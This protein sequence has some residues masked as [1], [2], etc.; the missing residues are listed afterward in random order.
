MVSRRS[1]AWIQLAARREQAARLEADRVDPL[2]HTVHR[3]L[4]DRQS[5][6]T[7]ELADLLHRIT[8]L[9]VD[10]RRPKLPRLIEPLGD[11][12]DH[13]YLACTAQQRAIRGEQADGAGAE[14]RDRAAGLHHR[15]LGRVP[16][17]DERVRQHREVILARIERLAGH[18]HTVGVG[19]WDPQELG[20]CAPV[21]AHPSVAVRRAEASRPH[22]Q[23]C[24]GVT[25]GAVEA[26]PAKQVRG[27][28]DPLALLDRPHCLTD[29]LDHAKRLVADHQSRFGTGAPVEHMQVG[30]TDRA[31]AHAHD[32]IGWLLDCGI[33]DIVDADTPGGLV[34]DSFH[35]SAPLLGCVT[36]VKSDPSA[37]GERTPRPLRGL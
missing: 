16:A 2:L 3:L 36:S 18:A 15:Q 5:T 4:A 6:A 17:G 28:H 8:I 31:R 10:R 1:R 19:E 9:E 22:A 11:I 32:H 14:Y 13:V 26:D 29:L 12:I 24:G 25:P 34:D 33:L 30:A 21:G 27:N 37:K 7:P 23:T 20:L 35:D